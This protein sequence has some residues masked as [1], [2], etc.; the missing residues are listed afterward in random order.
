MRE[1]K[2]PH[3]LKCIKFTDDIFWKNIF[4]ELSFGI[5]PYNTFIRK[6]YLISNIKNK[7]FNYK[8]DEDDEPSKVFNDLYNLLYTK[9]GLISD[10]QIKEDE[11]SFENHNKKKILKYSII[12][13]FCTRKSREHN[14]T[15]INTKKLI[16]Y[17]NLSL[18][19]RNLSADEIEYDENGYI[20]HVKS[21]DFND[22]N[23]IL[24]NMFQNSSYTNNDTIVEYDFMY[25]NWVKY[26]NNL[27][28]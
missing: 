26:I 27:I 11:I 7:E 22:N 24:D 5:P 6:N 17:I 2:Y 3:F 4:E 1:L 18:V 19:I 15:I 23:I 8:I 12:E 16:N 10:I 21:I 28:I 9:F 13:E 20:I 25:N 14:L